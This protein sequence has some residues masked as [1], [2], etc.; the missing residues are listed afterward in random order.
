MGDWLVD[1]VLIDPRMRKPSQGDQLPSWQ[2]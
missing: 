2:T 1:D